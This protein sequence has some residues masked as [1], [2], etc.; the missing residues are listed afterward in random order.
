[1]SEVDVDDRTGALEEI[2]LYAAESSD[3]SGDDSIG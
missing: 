1:V 2:E 3:D